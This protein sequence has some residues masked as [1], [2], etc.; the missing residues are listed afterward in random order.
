M[1]SNKKYFSPKLFEFRIKY[2]AGSGHSAQDSYHYYSAEDAQQ[3]LGYHESMMERRGYR[4]Q[5]I[6]I[7]KNNPYSNKWEEITLNEN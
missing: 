3:A 1:S 7:E 6:S 4:S 5:L 2:N